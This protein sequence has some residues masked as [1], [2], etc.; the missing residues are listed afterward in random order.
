MAKKS[1][2]SPEYLRKRLR[3]DPETGALFWRASDD[4]PKEW[5]TRRA[6][7]EAFTTTMKNGYKMGRVLG[8]GLTAHRVIMAMV[9][10]EWPPVDVDHINRDRADNR[11]SNLRLASRQENLRNTSAATSSG[12]TGVTW[13]K[14]YRKWVAQIGVDYGNVYLGRFE[15]KDD[16][17]AARRAAEVAHGFHQLFSLHV[18][19]A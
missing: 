1:L 15:S 13:S 17:I 2:P 3:Y 9:N 11:L 12:V 5:N 8:V 19:D 7:R 4:M 16:A 18:S 10:D 6:G 14:R